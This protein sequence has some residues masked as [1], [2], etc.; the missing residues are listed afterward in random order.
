MCSDVSDRPFTGFLLLN[1]AFG[2]EQD[3]QS[4]K[5]QAVFPRNRTLFYLKKEIWHA[6][7]SFFLSFA[8]KMGTA[9]R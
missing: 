8:T 4:A 5:A 7:V 6:Y 3:F 2:T 1:T 9:C